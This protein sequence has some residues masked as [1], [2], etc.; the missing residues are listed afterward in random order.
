MRLV[1]AAVLL[2]CLLAPAGGRTQSVDPGRADEG[3]ASFKTWLDR[4]HA[5]YG[6]DEGPGR[7]RNATVEAAYPGQRFYYVL[8]HTRGIPPPFQKALTLV[9]R[10][11]GNGAVAP[12]NATSPATFQTG[13]ARVA[14]ANQA[15]RAAAA[16]LIL[17]L[18]DPGQ[19]RWR[20]EESLVRVRRLRKGWECTYAHGDR[21]HVSLVSF[22]RRGTITAIHCNTPPVP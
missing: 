21:A 20:I 7:F 3:L 15:R 1:G 19:R 17:T 10:I 22:D 14:S 12:L 11:G 2:A 9:V 6:C 13:L 4:E 5:G 16:V 18:G 8:T